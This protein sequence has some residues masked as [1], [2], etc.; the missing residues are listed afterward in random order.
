VLAVEGFVV[1]SRL[2]DDPLQRRA[3]SLR[4]LSLAATT[5]PLVILGGFF[6]TFATCPFACP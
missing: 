3:V 2:R 4:S 1:Q 6:L 5:V